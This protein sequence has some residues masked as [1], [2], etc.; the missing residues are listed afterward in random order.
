MVS[1]RSSEKKPAGVFYIPSL[2]LVDREHRKPCITQH[3]WEQGLEFFPDLGKKRKTVFELALDTIVYLL[4]R[5]LRA[6]EHD[7]TS[8]DEPSC[9]HMIA[10]IHRLPV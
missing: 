1:I 2:T 9:T 10:T 6:S 8:T 3:P 4:N 7:W 5:I